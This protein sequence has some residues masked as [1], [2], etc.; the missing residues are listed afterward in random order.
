MIG[1]HKYQDLRK[2]EEFIIVSVL[3]PISH[4]I[5]VYIV[6]LWKNQEILKY[7]FWKLL[8]IT[9]VWPIMCER[10]EIIPLILRECLVSS[11]WPS[12]P[13]CQV[14]SNLLLRLP[15]SVVRCWHYPVV[16]RQQLHRREWKWTN[17]GYQLVGLVLKCFEAW[18]SAREVWN[19]ENSK[20]LKDL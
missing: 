9:A 13:K 19:S 8:K 3:E 17:Q 4:S 16:L 15:K 11:N 2:E 7:I 6:F 12:R 10:V 5:T 14:P 1:T 18:Y 20:A